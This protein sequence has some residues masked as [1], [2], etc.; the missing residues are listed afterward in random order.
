[1]W[2]YCI[3]ALSLSKANWIPN[4]HRYRHRVHTKPSPELAKQHQQ[5]VHIKGILS[6]LP[7]W[8]WLIGSRIKVDIN[9]GKLDRSFHLAYAFASAGCLILAPKWVLLLSNCI[10]TYIRIVQGI[11]FIN[12]SHNSITYLFKLNSIVVCVSYPYILSTNVLPR[13]DQYQVV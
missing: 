11:F 8:Y 2:W 6:C 12:I 1:M 7:Q 10:L 3:G 5:P 4:L 13:F 9:P